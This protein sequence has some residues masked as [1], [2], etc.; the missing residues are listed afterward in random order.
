MKL[1]DFDAYIAAGEALASMNPLAYARMAYLSSEDPQVFDDAR[2]ISFL[3]PTVTTPQ[4]DWQFYSSTI[5][6]INGGPAT[7]LE[8]F[9]NRTQTTLNWL[10]E[11]LIVCTSCGPCY[12][13]NAQRQQAMECD[14]FVGTRGSSWN[15]L[16]DVCLLWSGRKTD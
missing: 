4:Q 16:I 9:G 5:D 10:M 8:A 14:A 12:A 15:R 2:A 11:L 3:D 13:A 7:Q 1:V 6:R